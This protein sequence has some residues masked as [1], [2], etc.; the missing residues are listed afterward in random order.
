MRP[1]HKFE[2]FKTG[3]TTLY[4]YGNGICITDS[5]ALNR[6]NDKELIELIGKFINSEENGYKQK[7]MT[8]A[9]VRELARRLKIINELKTY[10]EIFD[11]NG[12]FKR[13]DKY[14][15]P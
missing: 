12:H 7:V 3:R 13:D 1:N 2:F 10:D 5:G 6:C 11:E 14:D 9:I 8:Y 4:V 15:K